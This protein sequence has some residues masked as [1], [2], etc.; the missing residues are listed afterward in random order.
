MQ[1]FVKYIDNKLYLFDIDPTIKFSKLIIM[2]K[3]KSKLK[4]NKVIFT[5]N[6]K[7]IYEHEKTLEELNIKK[8]DEI[9]TKVKVSCYGFIFL[10]NHQNNDFINLD[11]EKPYI[12][13][14]YVRVDENNN[15]ASTIFE[16]IN[17][18]F[19]HN[20]VRLHMYNKQYYYADRLLDIHTPLSKYDYISTS[21]IKEQAIIIFN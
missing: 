4:Y 19:R 15:I 13:R 6:G 11:K 17:N 21:T 18:I 3:N 9:K 16:C 5:H 8:D 10:L 14:T 20:S 2:L 12:L 1:I 7:I